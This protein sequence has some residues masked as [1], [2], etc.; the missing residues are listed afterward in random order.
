MPAPAGPGE[1]LYVAEPRAQRRQRSRDM[2]FELCGAEGSQRVVT[3]TVIADLMAAREEALHVAPRKKLGRRHGQLA[4]A[5]V[6]DRVVLPLVG[7]RVA[8]EE[9]GGNAVLVEDLRR[10]Q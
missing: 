10:A 1:M 4:H 8:D 9:T 3:P 5:E 7:H 6:A 2:I